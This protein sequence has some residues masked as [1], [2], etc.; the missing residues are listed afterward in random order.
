[1]YTYRIQK[2]PPVSRIRREIKRVAPIYLF[3]EMERA[4]IEPAFAT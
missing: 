4:G 3:K 2:K 1:M